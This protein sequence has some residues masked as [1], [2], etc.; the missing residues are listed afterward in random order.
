MTAQDALLQVVV[1]I[2]VT[3]VR[4]IALVSYDIFLAAAAA[5]NDTSSD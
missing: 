4:L 2:V 1:F 5:Q 3:Q